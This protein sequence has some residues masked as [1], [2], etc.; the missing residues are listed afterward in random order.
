M[1]HGVMLHQMGFFAGMD[2]HDLIV[3]LVIYL[4]NYLGTKHANG[5]KAE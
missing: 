3:G 2:W 1:G 4:A 5:S